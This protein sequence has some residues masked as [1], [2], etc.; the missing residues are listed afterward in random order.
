DF[1]PLRGAVE[2]GLLAKDPVKRHRREG[3]P[4]HSKREDRGHQPEPEVAGRNRA[5]RFTV[6]LAIVMRNR[7]TTKAPSRSP[8]TLARAFGRARMTSSSRLVMP[9]PS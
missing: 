5:H 6:S 7:R 3:E 4:D 1:G 2:S 8:V 9:R